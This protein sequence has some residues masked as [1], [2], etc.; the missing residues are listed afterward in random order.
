MSLLLVLL[1][2][3]NCHCSGLSFSLNIPFLNAYL[4]EILKLFF[5]FFL[6]HIQNQL[7]NVRTLRQ[8]GYSVLSFGNL[9]SALSTY[10]LSFVSKLEIAYQYFIIFIQ[11]IISLCS[12]LN[13]YDLT[14][15]IHVCRNFHSSLHLTCGK[16]EI[17][18]YW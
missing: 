1:G 10:L 18:S 14:L 9:S 12:L 11:Q 4:K 3:L 16:R 13:F 7:N 6:P 8:L 5:Y 2:N 15:S 17:D